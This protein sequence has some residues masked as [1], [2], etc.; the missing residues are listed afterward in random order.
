MLSRAVE[1]NGSKER[2]CALEAVVESRHMPR[3][4]GL[5]SI[6][7]FPMQLPQTDIGCHKSITL[8]LMSAPRGSWRG[9]PY[10]AMNHR[11]GLDFQRAASR[12]GQA[13]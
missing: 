13:S 6:D 8:L 4:I 9:P 12:L 2:D 1:D 5:V 7:H 11:Y 3:D 10:T